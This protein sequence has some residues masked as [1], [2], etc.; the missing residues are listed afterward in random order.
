M[1][2]IIIFIWVGKSKAKNIYLSKDINE[3]L[4]FNN[5]LTLNE[6][7]EGHLDLRPLHLAH[8]NNQDKW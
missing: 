5:H 2:S 7:F 4:K 8:Q 1:L 6:K 3:L